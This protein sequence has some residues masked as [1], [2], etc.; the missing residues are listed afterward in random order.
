MEMEKM[1]HTEVF[2]GWREREFKRDDL[3]E[4]VDL[5]KAGFGNLWSK[6]RIEMV[7]DFLL[8]S[9]GLHVEAGRN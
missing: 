9:E 7:L 8:E 1:V 4:R 3:W 2:M 6:L 5:W